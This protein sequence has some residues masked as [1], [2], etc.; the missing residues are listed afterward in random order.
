MTLFKQPILCLLSILCFAV[1]SPATGQ[2]GDQGSNLDSPEVLEQQEHAL[3]RLSEIRRSLAQKRQDIENLKKQPQEE[4]EADAEEIRNEL[5]ELHSE[6]DELNQSFEQIVIG[7]IDTTLVTEEATEEFDWR[8]E[9]VLITKPVLSSLKNLT[10]KPRRIEELRSAIAR[11]ELQLNVVQRALASIVLI[12]QQQPPPGVAEEIGVVADNWRQR[13]HAIERSQDVAKLQLKELE[14]D[15]TPVIESFRLILNSFV[16]GRGLTLLLAIVAGVIAWAAMSGLRRLFGLGSG[17]D[18]NRK[19]PVRIRVL[20]YT[21]HLATALFVTLAVL[22]VFYVRQDI[23]LL[24]LALIALAVLALGARQFIPRYVAQSRLLLDV[25]PVREGERIVY[26][27]VP[28]LVEHLNVYTELRNPRLEGTVRLPLGALEQQV[29]RPCADESWF[30]CS[31]GDYVELPGGGVVEIVQQTVELVRFRRRD[32][33]TQVATA[34]FLG[35]GVRNLSQEGFGV[36]S[37][38]GIDYRHQGIALNQVPM[39]FEKAV[40]ETLKTADLWHEVKDVLVDFKEAGT[41]SLDYLLYVTMNGRAA[42]SYFTIPRLVQQACVSVCNEEG[43][44]IPF[45]QVTIHD[46]SRG[47]ETETTVLGQ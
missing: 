30:P 40:R 6:V 33:I 43:W 17:A 4:G 45:T 7:G 41:N 13:K 27:G 29:S 21:Y 2:T 47:A 42:A 44:E 31:V 20:L 24:A 9:L 18:G 37:T 35:L 23:L 16:L 39:R 28:L 1:T 15:D 32:S 46:A 10:E 12:E 3:R 8:E 14:R 19:H 11:H 22:G 26:N 25:G 34:D 38:F 36:V 5:L